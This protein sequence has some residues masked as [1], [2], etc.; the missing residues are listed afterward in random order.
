MEKLS[1][2]FEGK[3]TKLIAAGLIALGIAL[4][5]GW[6]DLSPEQQA[7][8]VVVLIG[9]GKFAARLAVAKL[10]KKVAEAKKIK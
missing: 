4:G 2:L 8:I 3:K 9:A 6:I 1:K 5:A 7:G 10:E